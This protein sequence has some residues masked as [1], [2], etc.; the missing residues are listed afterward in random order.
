[1]AHIPIWK[2]ITRRHGRCLFQEPFPPSQAWGCRYL[3]LGDVSFAYL[4]DK[5]QRKVAGATAAT[6]PTNSSSAISRHDQPRDRPAGQ[7]MC[8]PCT[9]AAGISAR[10]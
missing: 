2:T 4:C 8:L 5:D 9:S 3:Q 10:I 7:D 1:M 6:I